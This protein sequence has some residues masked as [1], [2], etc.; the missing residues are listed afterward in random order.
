M[1][2]WNKHLNDNSVLLAS[3]PKKIDEV[4]NSSLSGNRI[5]PIG[6]SKLHCDP[7]CEF[8]QLRANPGTSLLVVNQLTG[9]LMINILDYSRLVSITK[10]SW[11]T[12]FCVW[13]CYVSS[14]II[15]HAHCSLVQK[16]V[17]VFI[18]TQTKYF[19]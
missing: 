7:P 4:Y 2:Y 1:N 3:A 13:Y 12:L 5:I 16:T 6:G 8:D 10:Y 18:H 14:L 19:L 11:W 15:S 17:S 9:M